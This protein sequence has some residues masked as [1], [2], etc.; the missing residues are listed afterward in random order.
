M[1]IYNN[2]NVVYDMSIAIYDVPCFLWYDHRGSAASFAASP[3][4][5]ASAGTEDG[6]AGARRVVQPT[7]RISLH[8]GS[9]ANRC[10]VWWVFLIWGDSFFMFVFSMLSDIWWWLATS[11]P[12]EYTKN[13]QNHP[14]IIS[15]S[16]PEPYFHH[17]LSMKSTVFAW[18][19]FGRA[20]FLQDQPYVPRKSGGEEGVGRDLWAGR[21]DTTVGRHGV[22]LMRW[23]VVDSDENWEK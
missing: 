13:H 14:Q 4:T 2:D 5:C 12:W 16:S 18:F 10:D 21:H 22:D 1:F 7:Q 3:G 11:W 19:L 20:I 17:V 9:L 23:Y 8:R 6:P 15:K